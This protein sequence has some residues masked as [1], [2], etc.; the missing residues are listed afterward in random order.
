MPLPFQIWALPE[1][2]SKPAPASVARCGVLG[3]P[4]PGSTGHVTMPPKYCPPR[5]FN[6]RT[7]DPCQTCWYFMPAGGERE[8]PFSPPAPERMQSHPPHNLG[9][10]CRDRHHKNYHLLHPCEYAAEMAPAA[11]AGKTAKGKNGNRIGAAEAVLMGAAAAGD[12]SPSTGR[13]ARRSASSRATSSGRSGSP[14]PAA[15]TTVTRPRAPTNHFAPP[16]DGMRADGERLTGRDGPP[17]APTRTPTQRKDVPSS[18]GKP[19][20]KRQRMAAADSAGATGGVS[21]LADY[22][23][24]QMDAFDGFPWAKGE[25]PPAGLI[26]IGYQIGLAEELMDLKHRT[27]TCYIYSSGDWMRYRNE[28]CFKCSCHSCRCDISRVPSCCVPGGAR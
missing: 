16:S 2:P 24:V 13:P 11:P 12:V 22:D 9:A 19:D 18:S 14:S 23:S 15:P 3:A 5:C 17:A 7:E 21:T 4:L 20:P 10:G 28:V 25:Y 1:V 26:I 27:P 6:I 8:P